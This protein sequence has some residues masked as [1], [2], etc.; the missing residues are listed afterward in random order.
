MKKIILAYILLIVSVSMQAQDIQIEP[1]F[2]WSDM[3][4]ETVQLMIHGDGIGEYK[5]STNSK[6][7]EIT[8]IQKADSPNYLFVDLTILNR[9]EEFEVQFKFT[10]GKNARQVSYQFNQRKKVE[11]GFDAKDLVYLIMPDRFSNGLESNDS[12]DE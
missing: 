8:N 4:H 12:T 9:K 11:R 6:N 1:P 10:D 5:I 7:I 2:W 3:V